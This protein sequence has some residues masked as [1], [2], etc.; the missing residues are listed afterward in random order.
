MFRRSGFLRFCICKKS[1]DCKNITVLLREPQNFGNLATT[2]RT[3]RPPCRVDRFGR[4]RQSTR[5]GNS[6]SH[7]GRMP[8]TRICRVPRILVSHPSTTVRCYPYRLSLTVWHHDGLRVIAVMGGGF[9]WLTKIH[10]YYKITSRTNLIN[11]LL[12]VHA[13][14]QFCNSARSVIR[15]PNF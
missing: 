12:R 9:P 8:P 13:P 10:D 6:L 1:A 11:F 3:V 7:R 14:P 2:G 4:L 5:P 15:P